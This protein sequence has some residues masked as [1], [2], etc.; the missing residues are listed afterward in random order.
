V[1][2]AG[3]EAQL[4]TNDPDLTE[5][6]STTFHVGLEATPPLAGG[7]GRFELNAFR[8]DLRDAFVLTAENDDPGTPEQELVRINAEKAH[9]QGVEATVGWLGGRFEGQVGWVVQ[10]GEYDAPQDFDETSF[11]RLPESYGVMRAY[12]RDPKLADLFVGLRYLGSQKMPH[13]AG[14]IDEDRLETT[15]AFWVLDLSLSRRLAFGDDS[16]AITV[17]VRNLTDVY[18]DDLDQGP[19]RDAGYLYGPRYPR[20]VF[21]SAGYEF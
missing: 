21:M 6:S 13:Y 20:T 14:C 16:V 15:E 9:V 4:I 7:F 19:E 2:I 8:T 3:G 12:W 17:G 10:K 5:E 18:Q 1:A 11:F